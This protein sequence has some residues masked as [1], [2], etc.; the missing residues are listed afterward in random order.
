LSTYTQA[1]AQDA[2]AKDDTNLIEIVVT[3]QRAALIRAEEIKKEAVGVVDSVSAEEA[4]KFPDANVAD[5]LQRVPGLSIDR[6]GGPFSTNGGDSSQVTIR[7][8]GPNFNN[9]LL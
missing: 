9:V 5:A 7:G 1:W 4:G 6:S 2:T 3:G 8:F